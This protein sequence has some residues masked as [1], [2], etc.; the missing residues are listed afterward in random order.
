M[1]DAI[2]VRQPAGSVIVRF[3]TQ[4]V[5]LGGPV[6]E[7]IVMASQPKTVVVTVGHQGPPGRDADA[8]TGAL[9]EVNRLSE[10][11]ADPQAQR[12]AQANL[13]LGLEDPLAYYILAKS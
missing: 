7:Q 10:F 12:D 4:N 6:R 3:P 8:V 1:P 9:R 13:G 5:V 11:A 2:I